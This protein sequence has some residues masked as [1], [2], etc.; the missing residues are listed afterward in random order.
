MRLHQKVALITG[1]SSGIGKETAL[2]FAKEGARVVLVD[3]ND[4]AGQAV[5]AEIQA[6]G[7]QAAYC[8]ADVAKASDCE[9]MIAFAEKQYGQLHI[10]FNNAG[11]MHSN[12]GDATGTEEDIFDLTLAINVKGVFFGC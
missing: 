11:I 3:I 4:D 2:L 5:C 9:A 7:G 6:A 1:G 8:H 10:L 12:D